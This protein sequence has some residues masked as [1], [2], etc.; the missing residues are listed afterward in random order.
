[1]MGAPLLPVA[2]FFLAAGAAVANSRAH[3]S[4]RTQSLTGSPRGG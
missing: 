4:S 3:N 2:S 1:M